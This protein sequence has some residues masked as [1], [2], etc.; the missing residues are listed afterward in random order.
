MFDFTNSDFRYEPYPICYAENVFPSNRY[1][2]LCDRF[3]PKDLFEYKPKKGKKYSLSERNNGRKYRDFVAREPVWKDFHA[4]VKSNRFIAD[5]LKFFD[6]KHVDLQQTGY[7]VVSKRES[8]RRSLMS[9]VLGRDELSARFEFSMM[10]PDGG[11]IRPHTDAPGKII[12]LVF[13]ILPPDQW[14]Q[15]WGGGTQVCLPKDRTKIYNQANNY[16]DFEGVDI[17]HSY[18]FH[19]N[20]CILFIKT[21]NSWHQV[22]PI[23]GPK[24]APDRKT[25]TINIERLS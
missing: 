23:N 10:G 22:A 17:V 11:H 24:D 3:P 12:T 15:D 20:Q 13:S 25:L 1:Q 21:Y 6:D 19:A 7:S 16:M 5:L 14:N 9:R 18:P 2:E 8:R 4:Y